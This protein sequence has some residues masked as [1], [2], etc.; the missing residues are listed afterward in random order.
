MSREM[1]VSDSVWV[2]ASPEVLYDLV[3]DVTQMPRWSPEN[4][5]GQVDQPGTPAYVGMRFVGSNRRGRARWRTSCEVTAA[6]RGQRFAFRVDRIG[7]RK[8]LIRGSIAEWEYA[9]HAVEN[10]T[11]VTETWRD[12]RRGWPDAVANAFDFVA[13]GGSTFAD[14]QCR[15][16][17][18]TLCNF[19]AAVER[20]TRQLNS[21]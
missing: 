20:E 3:S 18:R 12:G 2:E 14:F 5:G 11:L 6:D 16:I 4:T 15:N 8:G 17:Q 10:G 7:G 21:G 1:T 19:K 13:T 9:F